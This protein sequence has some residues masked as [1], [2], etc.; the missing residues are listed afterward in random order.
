MWNVIP[1]NRPN[2]LEV[3]NIVTNI[4]YNIKNNKCIKFRNIFN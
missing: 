1:E 2:M 4:D 3:L